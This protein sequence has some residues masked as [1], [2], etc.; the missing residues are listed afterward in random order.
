MVAE[1]VSFDSVSL[2]DICMLSL[3]I[4]CH[5]LFNY[6]IYHLIMILPGRRGLDCDVVY[7]VDLL[8]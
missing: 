4:Y 8:C 6:L 5:E 3:M 1:S 7:T 2:I